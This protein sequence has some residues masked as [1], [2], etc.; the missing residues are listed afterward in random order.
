MNESEERR[1]QL[2]K[3]T[4]RLYNEDRFIPAVH[5]RYGHIYKDLYDEEET[6]PQNSF[7]FRLMLGIICFVCY[8]WIDYGEIKVASVSSNQIVHQIEK[9]MDLKEIKAVWKNL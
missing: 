3:Q 4:K 8:V 7:Y 9:E 5:P 1:R 2:L 6:P